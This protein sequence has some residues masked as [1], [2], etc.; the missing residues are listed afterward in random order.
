[1]KALSHLAFDQAGPHFE[2]VH[3]LDHQRKAIRPVVA[4]P[5]QQPDANEIS[6]RHQPI[7]VVLDLVEVESHAGTNDV[8]IDCPNPSGIDSWSALR[9]GPRLPHLPRL[10]GA[11][12]I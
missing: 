5:G 8:G 3:G 4:V 9:D 2:V 6:T 10:H 12:I 7:A 1:M 11:A